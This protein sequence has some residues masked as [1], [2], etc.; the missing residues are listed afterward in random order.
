LSI[1]I[2]RNIRVI[3]QLRLQA[4]REQSVQDR[5]AAALT[6]SSG[7]MVFVYVHIVWFG[8]RLLLNTGRAVIRPFDPCPYG[9]LTMVVSIV[10]VVGLVRGCKCVCLPIGQGLF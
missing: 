10:G 9:L 5:L 4:A 1:V 2:E 3:S 6:F 8:I 7:R